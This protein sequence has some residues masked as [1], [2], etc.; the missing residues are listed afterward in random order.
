MRKKMKTMRKNLIFM[1]KYFIF[2]PAKTSGLSNFETLLRLKPDFTGLG[3]ILSRFPGKSSAG[4]QPTANRTADGVWP[5]VGLTCRSA[6]I[7]RRRG[8]ARPAGSRRGFCPFQY[9][10]RFQRQIVVDKTENRAYNVFMPA[11]LK[12]KTKYNE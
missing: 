8:G 5:E 11:L 1:R 9:G 6:P 4:D 10:R 2:F 12:R 7:S 3:G